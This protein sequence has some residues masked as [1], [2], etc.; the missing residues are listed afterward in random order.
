MQDHY[1]KEDTMAQ[2][3]KADMKTGE[4]AYGGFVYKVES[5]GVRRKLSV[6]LGKDAAEVERRNVLARQNSG[7][8]MKVGTGVAYGHGAPEA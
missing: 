1:D 2:P 8:A 6:D 5:N 7:L 4:I 3:T